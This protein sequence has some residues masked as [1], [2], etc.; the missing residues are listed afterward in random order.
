MQTENRHT[1]DVAINIFAKPFQTALALLSLIRHCKQNINV[2]WLQFETVAS[3]YDI[4]SP[5]L[6]AD[7]LQNEMHIKC[8][9]SQPETWL[10]LNPP[11]ESRLN[12]KSYRMN[13]RYECAFENSN[14]DYLFIMHND[15]FI[16][17]DI[18]GALIKNLEDAFI[19]GQLGQCWNCPASN[20]ELSQEIMDCEK[21]SPQRYFCYR[22]NL[23]QLKQLYALARKKNIFARPY[24]KGFDELYADAPWPLPECR[25]NEWSCL[26]NMKKIR[27]YLYPN[28]SCFPFGAFKQCGDYTLDTSVFWFKELHNKG[29]KAKHFDLTKYLKHW[30][31]T[32]K[33]TKLK[34]TYTENKALKILNKLFPEYLLWLEQKTGL[35]A[36]HKHF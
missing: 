31:G 18:I 32:G 10:D 9:A 3:K 26:V 30:G 20:S 6:I 7:Y 16:I 34:Y 13:I 5:Y 1:A 8:H 12:E 23:N 27:N 15:V 22:P 28:G 21:C 4:V 11:D 17:K 35:A 36:I 25:V 33:N 2:V 14:A 24:E 29:F 19:I